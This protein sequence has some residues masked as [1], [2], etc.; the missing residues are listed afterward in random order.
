MP[1]I[2]LI[3]DSRVQ[4]HTY[5]RLLEDAGHRVRHAATAEDG[6]QMCVAATPDLVVLDQYLG[7]K[8]GLDVCRRIKGD[9][10]L[11]LIPILVLTGSQKE[12]DHIAA[13]DAGADRFL[14]KDS[15]LSLIHI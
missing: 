15:P 13:L 12:R 1:D 4:A 8:S 6:F 3:E 11:Q 2:L 9:A 5:K 14:S 7:D 10:W